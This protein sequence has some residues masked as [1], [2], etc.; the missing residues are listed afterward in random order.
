[1]NKPTNFKKKEPVNGVSNITKSIGNQLNNNQPAISLAVLKERKKSLKGQN[2]PFKEEGSAPS[3][4][5]AAPEK[6][7]TDG[8]ENKSYKKAKFV[9]RPIIKKPA[10]ME[11]VTLPIIQ[12]KDESGVELRI[13]AGREESNSS[14]M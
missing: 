8:K 12:Y 9:K 5:P 1:M 4:E 3:E 13:G 14:L 10:S 11:A 6:I 2:T 7:Y